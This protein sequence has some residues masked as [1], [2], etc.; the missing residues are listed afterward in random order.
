MAMP[1][2]E[3]DWWKARTK[4]KENTR[5]RSADHTLY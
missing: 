2:I 1:N 5:W 4:E 3:L